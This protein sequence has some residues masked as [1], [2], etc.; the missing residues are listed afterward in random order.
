EE[1]NKALK[2]EE[3]GDT[4][5]YDVED[6]QLRSQA[7]SLRAAD[8]QQHTSNLQFGQSRGVFEALHSSGEQSQSAQRITSRCIPCERGTSLNTIRTS[9]ICM[10][11]IR[12]VKLKNPPSKAQREEV[13]RKRAEAEKWGVKFDETFFTVGRY[14]RDLIR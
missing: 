5:K 11:F 2:E 13:D 1:L 3:G 6:V 4:D 8:Q 12:L 7:R 14:D 10:W 9:T